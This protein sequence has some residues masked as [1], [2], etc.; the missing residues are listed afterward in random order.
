MEMN[1]RMTEDQATKVLNKALQ[2]EQDYGEYF[3]AVASGDTAEEIYNEVKQVI[4]DQSG[5][6]IWVPAKEK[7]WRWRTDCHQN[8]SCYFYV[9]TWLFSKL[10]LMV[11]FFRL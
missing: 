1:K 10:H 2:L 6:T 3:T 4:R 5:P 9:Q 7:L 8:V 11:D